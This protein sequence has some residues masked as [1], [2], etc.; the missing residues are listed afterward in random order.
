MFQLRRN[1]VAWGVLWLLLAAIGC[2]SGTGYVT[3]EGLAMPI[4]L[5]ASVEREWRQV[6]LRQLY[7]VPREPGIDLYMP[8]PFTIGSDGAL[9]YMDSG[10]MKIKHFDADGFFKQSYGGLGEGPGEFR[11][12]TEADILGDSVLYVTDLTRRTISFFAVDSATFLYSIP[13]IHAHKYKITQGGRAY[14][15]DLESDSLLGTSVG[16]HDARF[17]GTMIKGQTAAHRLLTGGHIVPY[18]EDIVYVPSRFPI[19]MRYDSIGTM[20]YARATPDFDTAELPSLERL[21]TSTGFGTRVQG[22]SHNGYTEIYGNKLVVYAFNAFDVYDADT[23]DYEYSVSVPWGRIYFASYDPIGK[24]VW[25]VRD[26]T[27][28]VYAIDP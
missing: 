25:Q 11:I 15:I 13:N 5:Q 17:L 12:F 22:R 21:T 4:Q 23:G 20:I 27:V 1:Q 26:T 8:G 6:S 9:Y 18:Q 14:W 16:I 2:N 24:R 3:F 19:L 28:A 7:E 10:D